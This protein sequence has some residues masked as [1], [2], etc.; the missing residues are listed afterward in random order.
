[1]LHTGDWK[2]TNKAKLTAAFP[3]HPPKL[4]SPKCILHIFHAGIVPTTPKDKDDLGKVQKKS[5]QN[6]KRIE[7][8]I[9]E[10]KSILGKKKERHNE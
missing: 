1:M 9:M 8:A 4:K 6:A 3:T 5:N 2:A 7:V 10:G